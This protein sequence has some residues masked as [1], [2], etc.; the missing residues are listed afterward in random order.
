MNHRVRV[1]S[2]REPLRG[3]TV[4]EPGWTGRYSDPDPARRAAGGRIEI[5][6]K[7]VGAIA[8]QIDNVGAWNN[9]ELPWKRHDILAKPRTIADRI[10]DGKSRGGFSS[11]PRGFRISPPP[12]CTPSTV[13]PAGGLKVGLPGLL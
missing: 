5:T 9:G 3:E 13:I 4:Q 2:S 6:M 1:H 8:D 10:I 7:D 11:S 12:R